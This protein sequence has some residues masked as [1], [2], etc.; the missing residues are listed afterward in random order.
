MTPQKRLSKVVRL[1][2]KGKPALATATARSSCK[3]IRRILFGI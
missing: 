3:E 1:A 2:G